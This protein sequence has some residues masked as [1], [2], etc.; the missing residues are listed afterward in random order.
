V[1]GATEDVIVAVDLLV[2]AAVGGGGRRGARLGVHGKLA[3]AKVDGLEAVLVDHEPHELGALTPS[4]DRVVTIKVAGRAALVVAKV[5]KMA[6][7]LSDASRGSCRPVQGR[8]RL[9]RAHS[10][11][12]E[13]MGRS[14]GP[15]I[16]REVP[17]GPA[18]SRSRSY[19]L[20]GAL[21][22][23]QPALVAA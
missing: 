23:P 9:G 2:P 18:E 7:R 14:F 22:Y 17:G 20:L 16:G 3:A 21:C 13:R 6:D 19:P 8:Q 5:H 4:D 10:G 15:L 11:Q 12:P 1:H